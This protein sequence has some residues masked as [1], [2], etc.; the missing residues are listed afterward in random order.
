MLDFPD[1]EVGPPQANAA[2]RGLWLACDAL[3][4]SAG[5]ANDDAAQCRQQLADSLI[6]CTSS[7]C[8]VPPKPY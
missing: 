1:T 8:V 6:S 4:A 2:C 3:L 7:E 5:T